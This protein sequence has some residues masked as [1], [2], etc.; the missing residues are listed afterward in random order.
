MSIVNEL[1]S[2]VAVALLSGRDSDDAK[3]LLDVLLVF[4]STLRS[5]STEA[6]AER[7]SRTS[8]KLPQTPGKGAAPLTH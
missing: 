5:L 4:H 2:E 1:S 6:R 7:R 3:D 8:T